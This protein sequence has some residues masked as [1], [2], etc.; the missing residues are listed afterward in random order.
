MDIRVSFT[1]TKTVRQT[2]ETTVSLDSDVISQAMVEEYGNN[3]RDALSSA[4]FELDGTDAQVTF[5]VDLGDLLSDFVSNNQLS[6]TTVTDEDIDSDY[7][8]DW[9]DIEDIQV[10]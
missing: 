2:V 1:G 9:E 4:D 7:D 10:I 5:T 6:D 3:L 8:S